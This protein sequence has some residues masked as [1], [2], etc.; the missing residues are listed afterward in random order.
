MNSINKNKQPSDRS[1]IILFSNKKMGAY[2]NVLNIVSRYFK[3][4]DLSG[5]N[6][7][8]NEHIFLEADLV[9]S[10]FNSN[11]V[12]GVALEID[13]FNIHAAPTWYRGAGGIARAIVDKQIK[14]G[15]VAHKMLY[16]YDAGDILIEE[17][18]DIENMRAKE[19]GEKC[20]TQA[21][22]LLNK[23]CI[24]YSKNNSLPDPDKK[25][26][27]SG[28][29]MYNGEFKKWLEKISFPGKKD[30]LEIYAPFFK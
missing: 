1:T 14:H 9:I 7:E 4:Y 20:V 19:I 30:V 29:I 10:I 27:W 21:L 22:N 12:E 16:E 6:L 11:R 25:A 18:F 2:Q 5:G 24:F 28:D 13:N 15:I 3:V 23:L 8:G 17:T 26:K